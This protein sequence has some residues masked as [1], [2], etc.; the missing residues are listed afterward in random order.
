MS[1]EYQIQM[2]MVATLLG[3]SNVVS[4]TKSEVDTAVALVDV[5]TE[6]YESRLEGERLEGE[7]E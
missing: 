7:G 1:N 5:I 2:M 6:I 3:R 4:I